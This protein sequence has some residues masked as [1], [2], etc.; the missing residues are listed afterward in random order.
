MK[1]SNGYKQLLLEI[2]S[3]I[4]ITQFTGEDGIDEYVQKNRV[5]IFIINTILE[6]EDSGS[7]YRFAQRLR[8]EKDYAMAFII[9]ITTEVDKKLPAYE[10]IGCYKFF[11]KPV[12]RNKLKEALRT[13]MGFDI[14]KRENTI[15][16]VAQKNKAFKLPFKDIVY[17]DIDKK[18]IYVHGING[19][20]LFQVSSYRY[21]LSKI[22]EKLGTKSFMRIHNSTIV[23]KSY[24]DY[25]DYSAKIVMLKDVGASKSAL[26]I[27]GSYI[28]KIK[29][30]WG[31]N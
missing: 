14:V 12:K 10:D 2:D 13:I 18:E 31:L 20:I 17:V 19:A 23:N 16:E 9:F 26:D 5:D 25:V 8:K 7:G 11:S 15:L 21:P 29:E 22:A 24:I 6:G 28:E 30:E 4:S 1:T 27:G 3:S